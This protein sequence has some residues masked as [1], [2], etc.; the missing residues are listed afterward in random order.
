MKKETPEN[1][2]TL[3]PPGGDTARSQEKKEK[4]IV[5]IVM[6]M[7]LH[8]DSEGNKGHYREGIYHI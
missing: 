6:L 8:E 7:T 5:E 3:F 4:K 2:F 1:S